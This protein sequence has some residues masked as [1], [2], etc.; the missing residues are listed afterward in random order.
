LFATDTGIPFS[1]ALLVFFISFCSRFI[2]G[3]HLIK[4]GRRYDEVGSRYCFCSK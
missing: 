1:L 4:T 2:R 3:C